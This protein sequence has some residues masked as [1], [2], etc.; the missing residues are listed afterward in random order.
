MDKRRAS[1]AD[2][3]VMSMAIGEAQ[4][5]GMAG[6]PTDRICGQKYGDLIV[7]DTQPAAWLLDRVGGMG[8]GRHG[9]L[10]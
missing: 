1:L 4:V 5:S 7:A 9:L 8:A 10:H 3:P 2:L 6:V